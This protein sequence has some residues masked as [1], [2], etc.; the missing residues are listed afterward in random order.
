M[1]PVQ[2]VR[3]SA[4]A[5]FR[6]SN[7]KN[8]PGG[9][10]SERLGTPEAVE[11]RWAAGR[12]GGVVDEEPRPVDEQPDPHPAAG[13]RLERGGD[14]AAGRVVLPAVDHQVHPPLGRADQGEQGPDGRLAG[15]QKGDG[16]RRRRAP[17]R[18]VEHAVPRPGVA[19]RPRRAE[20]FRHLAPAH[21]DPLQLAPGGLGRRA[22]GVAEEERGGSRYD[23]PGDRHLL[24]RSDLRV[25][26]VDPRPGPGVLGQ[27]AGVAVAGTGRRFLPARRRAEREKTGRRCGAGPRGQPT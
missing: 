17:E 7:R 11:E 12:G 8:G 9:S 10:M 23:F 20:V 16:G 22:D 19:R 3:P 4:T 5:S 1:P 14:L 15:R 27:H 2:A 18:A 24:R 25:L 26:D 21:G 6:W 13:R